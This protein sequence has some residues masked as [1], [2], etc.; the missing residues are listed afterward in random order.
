MQSSR[1]IS[2]SEAGMNVG[3]LL[4]KI[5]YYNQDRLEWS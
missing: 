4:I 5:D 1:I 3:K 2:L